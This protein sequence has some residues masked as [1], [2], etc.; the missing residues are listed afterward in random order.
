MI[1]IC[2]HNHRDKVE[3]PECKCG[4]LEEWE[5]AQRGEDIM[6]DKIKN[7]VMHYWTDHKIETIV[8]VVLVIAL[9]IK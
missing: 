7:S 9:I 8:V 5:S 1:C 4:H 3:C 6:L 2:G